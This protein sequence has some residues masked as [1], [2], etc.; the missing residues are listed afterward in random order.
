MPFVNVTSIIMNE[1]ANDLQDMIMN[2]PEARLAYE[3]F[4]AECRFR[5]EFDT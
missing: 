4:E 5:R 1:E 2:N 3:Q